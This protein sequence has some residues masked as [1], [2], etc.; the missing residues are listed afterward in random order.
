MVGPLQADH[1][2]VARTVSRKEGS[3]PAAREGQPLGP[4]GAA[5]NQEGTTGKPSRKT[6]RR[7]YSHSKKVTA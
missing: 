6:R 7:N 1:E 5:E 2:E 4:A 3:V